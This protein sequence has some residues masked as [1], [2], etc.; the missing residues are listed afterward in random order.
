[1][2]DAKVYTIAGHIPAVM[3][4]SIRQIPLF[5]VLSAMNPP[6]SVRIT[7]LDD[8]RL[9]VYRSL[10]TTNQNRWSKLFIA[11]GTTLVER[12]FQSDF[13]VDS[14]LASDQKLRNF[15]SRIPADANVFH[16]D[17]SLAAELVGYSFH[18]GVLAAAR[19][20]PLPELSDVIPATGPSLILFADQITDQQNLGLII[21]IASAFGATAVVVGPG[22]TDPFSRR[23][24]RVSMGNGLFFP[25]VESNNAVDSIVG[26]K[27]LGHTCYATVLDSNADELSATHFSKRS[28]LV[29]GN[30]T[31]GICTEILAACDKRLTISMLNGTD[32]LNVA[33][34]TGIFAHGYRSQISVD[35]LK[36][37]I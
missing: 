6:N 11:E 14:V 37:E 18:T 24:L 15:Q 29:V 33:I 23:V 31:H 21:R 28:V 5:A 35:G 34:A 2:E 16:M 17:R 9:D 7:D 3:L 19:R 10:R 36:R 32:S 20:K 8:P 1:M 25:I 30:E 12:L 27:A 4:L 13:E 26:L 22:S